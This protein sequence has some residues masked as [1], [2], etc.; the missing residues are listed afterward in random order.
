MAVRTLL[1]SVGVGAALAL[2]TMVA[3]AQAAPA[4]ASDVGSLSCTA[5]ITPAPGYRCLSS[6]DTEAQCD[7]GVLRHISATPATSGYCASAA[8]SWWGFVN[9]Y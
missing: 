9:I 6:Y 4:P 7:T 3:P 2:G 1:A 8:G 5:P